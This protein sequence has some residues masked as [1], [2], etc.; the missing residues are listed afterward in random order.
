M[1]TMGDSTCL[2]QQQPFS[3]VAGLPNDSNQL[4]PLAQSISFGR[5]VSDSLDWDKWS[6]FSHNR[7][8]E[9]A[10]R[11]SRPGSVAQKKAFF[12]AHYKNLAARKAAAL[13]EQAAKNDPQPAQQEVGAQDSG[14][15]LTNSESKGMNT[16]ERFVCY[17]GGEKQELVSKI[18]EEEVVVLSNKN[19]M[20]ADKVECSGQLD[21]ADKKNLK[22]E[23]SAAKL[24]E[25]PLLKDCISDTDDLAS[26]SKKKPAPPKL[27][28]FPDKPAALLSARK[29]NNTTTPISKK[30]PKSNHK[31]MNFTP[32]REIN[33]TSRIIRKIDNSRVNL[34]S[35]PSKDCST[36]TTVSVFRETKHALATPQ[37][38]SRR[39]INQITSRIIR[40][41]DDSRVTLNSKASKDCSTPTT[42]PMLRE[43]KHALA[44]PQS[45]S[46]RV[47]TP[48]QP[49]ASGRKSIRS[50][51]H[52][53]PTDCSKF[54]SASRNKSP[55][56]NLSTP[57]KLRTE[58]R[59]ARRKERLE[60]KFISH[61]TQKAQLQTTLKE[62]AEAELKKLRQS[63]C[64]KARPLPKFYKETRTN[65]MEKVPLTRQ[66]SPSPKMV[67]ATAQPQPQ[68]S[69]F[70]NGGS[71]HA[72]RKKN[73]NTLS[74]ASQLRSITH[75][76]T[77]PNIPNERAA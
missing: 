49:S 71:K 42:V 12:E 30:P 1:A 10:E 70:K 3:Y 56:S 2:I 28:C 67:Q 17:D 13:L 18:Q 9:E 31:S 64:F 61:Q 50:K 53:L 60:E 57:L 29:E 62:K 34:N 44:T 51:W 40:K 69:S 43:T 25:K 19:E 26:M 74:L 41:I 55:S 37:S 66:Q 48:L 35:K 46:R 22:E 75:E 4:H 8:V 77:S 73:E 54:M 52:F 32:V 27:P 15:L 39:E 36:P 58:D 23:I 6:S 63:L 65:Q 16:E 24:M 47:K 21:I 11:F 45:E 20:V 14:I 33:I 38:E 5:F 59:A 7:Y 76:N 72:I 68:R